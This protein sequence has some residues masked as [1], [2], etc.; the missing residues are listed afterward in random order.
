MKIIIAGGTGQIGQ[1]LANAFNNDGHQVVVMGRTPRAAV[2]PTVTWDGQTVGAWAEEFDGADVVIN[3]AGRS[4]NCRYNSSNRKEILDSRIDSVKAVGAA[5]SQATHPPALWLQMSTATIYAH[6]YDAPNDEITG[7]LGGNEPN[8]PDTWR[9]S[10]EVAKAWE[11]ALDETATPRTRK[12]KL[13]TAMVMSPDAGGVFAVLLGLVRKGLGGKAGDGRQYVSWIHGEDFVRAVNWLIQHENITGAVN[14]AAPEPLPN[15][16]FMSALRVA[17]GSS[18]GLPATKLM[19]EIGAVF[20][21][22]ETELIL[23]SRRVV[24]KLLVDSGFVFRHPRWP[25]AARDLCQKWSALH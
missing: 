24:P 11:Q 25:E 10:I 8:A 3:L 21:R 15:A 13:R 6:R 16:D 18:V 17:S 7:I 1:I 23:K 14:L 20:L 2:W 19:L 12:I 9:F 4:V 22:T 5:I